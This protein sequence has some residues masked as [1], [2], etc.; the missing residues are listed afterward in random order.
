MKGRKETN[1]LSNADQK[2]NCFITISVFHFDL[3]DTISK[4][5]GLQS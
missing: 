4:Q 5:A 2:K 3:R 1:S